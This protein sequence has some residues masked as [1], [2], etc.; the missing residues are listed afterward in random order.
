MAVLHG[1]EVNLKHR[2]FR[3]LTRLA[4]QKADL[5]VAVSEFTYSLLPEKLKKKPFRIIPNGID[6]AE[7][8]FLDKRSESIEINGFPSLL[9]V[10]NVTPRKGQHRVIKALPH[11]VKQYP[12]IHYHIV[13]L[14]TCKD[15][16]LG[17]AQELGVSSHVTFHGR[18]AGREQLAAMYKSSD[19]FAILSENQKD[20]DVEGFGIV[21]LEANYFGLPAIGALGCGIADA[22]ENGTNGFLVDGDNPQQIGDALKNIL[23][24]P[25]HFAEGSRRWAALH[26]W[27]V[28]GRQFAQ[29]L[30]F[31]C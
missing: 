19:C 25:E 31:T 28:I 11:L 1:S 18:L 14:P 7:F 26:D 5:L 15:D 27:E 13:G 16:F 24:A 30:A 21:V 22:I 17:L 3:I 9:T 29:A 4:L 12:E 6:V 8:S 10:G 20:G 23:V 2:L